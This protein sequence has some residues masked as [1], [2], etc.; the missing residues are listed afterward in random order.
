MDQHWYLLKN[1]FL[2]L[3]VGFLGG[4]QAPN[5]CIST[6]NWCVVGI[7]TLTPIKPSAFPNPTLTL[8]PHSNGPALAVIWYGFPGHISWHCGINLVCRPEFDTYA[9]QK[10]I[11]G[12]SSSL[13][14]A[15]WSVFKWKIHLLS[16]CKSLVLYYH[17]CDYKKI[18][19]NTQNQSIETE[20]AASWTWRATDNYISLLLMVLLCSI[21][22]VLTGQMVLPTSW[23]PHKLKRR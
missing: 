6:I 18:C 2:F 7:L 1:I 4:W 20:W 15:G 10:N 5:W 17:L 22:R 14:P 11:R 8:N 9:L 23:S 21:I 3:Y 13:R 19:W 16:A 12:D